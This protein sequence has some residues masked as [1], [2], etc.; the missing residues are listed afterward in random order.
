MD[1]E[2][3][4]LESY[5]EI[6]KARFEERLT[7][8]FDIDPSIRSMKVP[9]MILQPLVENAIKHGIG[10]KVGGGEV[11]ISGKL[12]PD[13]VIIAIEDTGVGQRPFSG[14]RG[15]GVG[16]ANVRERLQHIYGGAGSLRLEPMSPVGTR[17]TL[18][19]PQFVGV[20]L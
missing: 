9:P 10:P 17:V 3:H 2:L 15:A 19:L 5:L 14:N 13:R 12:G 4:F 1:D 6:E 20:P 16:L 18:T 11:C 8:A 7:Y